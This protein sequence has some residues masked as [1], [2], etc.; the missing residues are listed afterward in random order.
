MK[1]RKQ[2]MIEFV[3]YHIHGDGEC[4][5]VVLKAWADKKIGRSR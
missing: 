1:D 5:N 4:N 2:R 3:N